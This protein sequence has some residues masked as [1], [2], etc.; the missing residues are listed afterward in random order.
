MTSIGGSQSYDETV[1]GWSP[2]GRSPDLGPID[3]TT[4]TA[5]NLPYPEVNGLRVVASAAP[6]LGTSIDFVTSNPSGPGVGVNFLSVVPLPAPGI[7]LDI[8][9]APG[10][11]AHVEI[12]RAHV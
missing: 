11:F 10:C 7:P 12:G 1:V 5:V 8:L 9:G 6:V 3:V 2:A 4:L